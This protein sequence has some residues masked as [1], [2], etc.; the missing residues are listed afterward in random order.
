MSPTPACRRKWRLPGEGTGAP[1][2]C[3]PG[4]RARQPLEKP[5][6][7]PHIRLPCLARRVAGEPHR[8]LGVLG[9]RLGLPPPSSVTAQAHAP[10]CLKR[11][12]V[13]WGRVPPLL[14]PQWE[15]LARPAEA[16]GEV[17]GRAGVRP[18]HAG[19][20]PWGAEPLPRAPAQDRPPAP[21]GAGTAAWGRAPGTWAA[22][23]ARR[24]AQPRLAV[25]PRPRGRPATLRGSGWSP[26]GPAAALLFA[27]SDLSEQLFIH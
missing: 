17:P 9:Q 21:C 5:L 16:Q 11:P 12:P 7:G 14:R 10:C 19:Q 25:A 15:L 2:L 18:P 1:Q 23:R 6:D 8:A 13:T 22:L 26:R 4:P 27:M 20:V 24:Q 3:T